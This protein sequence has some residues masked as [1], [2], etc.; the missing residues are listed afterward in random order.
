MAV[1]N[2]R[3]SAWPSARTIKDKHSEVHYLLSGGRRRRETLAWIGLVDIM[4]Y[5]SWNHGVSAYDSA[6]PNASAYNNRASASDSTSAYI[7][8][9]DAGGGEDAAAA[10]GGEDAAPAVLTNAA[11]AG[12]EA[13]DAATGGEDAA[14]GGEAAAPAVLTN[15]AAGGEAAADIIPR[16]PPGPPP[17]LD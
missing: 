7:E 13:E 1:E 17:P 6:S 14:T 5:N 10:T 12:G 2:I 11:A 15:A 3:T 9:A 16:T 8:D 4:Q